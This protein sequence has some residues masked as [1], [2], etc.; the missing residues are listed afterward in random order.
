M[1]YS[2]HF[3][4]ACKISV[5]HFKNQVMTWQRYTAAGC[6]A[7]AGLLVAFLILR[8]EEANAFG[9]LSVAFLVVLAGALLAWS[10]LPDD[11]PHSQNMAASDVL[12]L[13]LDDLTRGSTRV[14]YQLASPSNRRITATDEHGGNHGSDVFD[15]MVRSGFAPMLQADDYVIS[16]VAERPNTASYNVVLFSSA[17]PTAAYRFDLSTVRE[18]DDHPSL[19]AFVLPPKSGFWRT[20]AAVPLDEEQRNLVLR[21]VKDQRQQLMRSRCFGAQANHPSIAHS[22]GEDAT[23]NLCCSLGPKAKAYADAS[24]NPIGA[25]AERIDVIGDKKT[26]N[27][28]TCM[29]SNVCGAYAAE[30]ADGTK[31]LFA[32]NQALNKVATDVPADPDCEAYAARLLTA[33]THSTPGIRTRGDPSLCIQ[34]DRVDA[35][36]LEI[37]RDID[38][39]LATS[40]A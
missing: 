36:L 4:G 32:T 16:P 6:A 33:P 15:H 3:L 25:A 1:V 34:K 12:R 20:D 18:A 19:G 22:F 14:A 8:H 26:S 13:Q 9:L 11:G 30:Q 24:G 23:H 37:Q 29:G 38:A 21:A 39:W 35:G 40:S 5:H 10:S 7:V 28:S 31:A 17:R 2:Y 27:W